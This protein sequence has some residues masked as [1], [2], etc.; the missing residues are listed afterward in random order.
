MDVNNRQINMFGIYGIYMVPIH[1]LMPVQI[2]IHI[3]RQCL[4][5]KPMY[6]YVYTHIVMTVYSVSGKQ[7]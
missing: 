7:V 6:V 4:I 3:H 2:H 5:G 1:I